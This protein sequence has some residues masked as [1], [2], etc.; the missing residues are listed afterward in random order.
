MIQTKLNLI[1]DQ[2]SYF[3]SKIGYFLVKQ[4]TKSQYKALPRLFG[5]ASL[6]SLAD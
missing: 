4:I 3:V 1:H 2:V 5:M 6:W